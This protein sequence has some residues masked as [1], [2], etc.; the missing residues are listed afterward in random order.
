MK[1]A[2]DRYYIE[3]KREAKP[4]LIRNRK[5]FMALLIKALGDD[6]ES[7]KE[8]NQRFGTKLISKSANGSTVSVIVDGEL[9][10]RI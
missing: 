5:D 3:I 10:Y 9:E 1:R 7:T 6:E 2:Y 8:L 4:V